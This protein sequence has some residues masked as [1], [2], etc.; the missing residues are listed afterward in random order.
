M[1]AARRASGAIEALLHDGLETAGH[2]D[3]FARVMGRM[4]ATE[5]A[6]Q[7]LAAVIATLLF[8]VGSHALVLW[9]SVGWAS[10]AAAL[11]ARLPER[12]SRDPEHSG[13]HD[14]DGDVD[15]E[16]GYLATLRAGVAEVATARGVRSAVLVLALVG[17][18]DA[19]DEYFPILARDWGVSTV[20]TPMSLA[21]ISLVGAAGATLAGRAQTWSSWWLG[22]ALGGAGLTL[23]LGGTKFPIGLLAVAAFYGAFRLVTVV[24]ETRLQARITGPSRATVGSVASMGIELSALAL[25]AG[26]AGGGLLAVAGIVVIAAAAVALDGAA[27]RVRG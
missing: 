20:M 10:C 3:S 16:L 19:I 4:R 14:A 23:L 27:R 25:F 13:P 21:V 26:W 8:A 24:L 1:W 5:L 7:P 6:V 9:T 22:S 11:A 18:I 2:I 15:P 17:G 12:S